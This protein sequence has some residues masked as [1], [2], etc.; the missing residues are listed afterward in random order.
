[1]TINEKYNIETT[2]S[3]DSNSK[4][5]LTYY[6][7]YQTFQ[8]PIDLI[9]LAMAAIFSDNTTPDLP[10]MVQN[11]TENLQQKSSSS[12][13]TT[14]T[15]DVENNNYQESFLRGQSISR[16]ERKQHSFGAM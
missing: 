9:M 13:T 3:I 2:K 16:I 11:A 5:A 8:G 1:M 4:C 7:H 10:R 15:T 12:A 14:T 6:N